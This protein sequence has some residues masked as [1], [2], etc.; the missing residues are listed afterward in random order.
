MEEEGSDVRG[1]TGQ[2]IGLN[3][4]MGSTA[5]QHV[6]GATDQGEECVTRAMGAV[7]LFAGRAKVIVN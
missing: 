1:V 6:P 5:A 2:V 3:T 4:K 7:W